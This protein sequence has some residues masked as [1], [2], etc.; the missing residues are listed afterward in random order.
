M[1][2]K[3]NICGEFLELLGRNLTLGQD[4]EV[5]FSQESN[6]RL[7]RRIGFRHEYDF[8]LGHGSR[9][10]YVDHSDKPLETFIKRVIMG[11]CLLPCLFLDYLC[12]FVLF[13][14]L[15]LTLLLQ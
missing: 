10:R 11:L 12:F 6:F 4:K 13:L 1:A 15:E 8:R 2:R 3:I 14:N 5:G 9:L 7:E